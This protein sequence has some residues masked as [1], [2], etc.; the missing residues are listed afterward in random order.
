MCSQVIDELEQY[1]AEANKSFSALFYYG[2]EL[3]QKVYFPAPSYGV[4][5]NTTLTV[6]YFT[7]FGLNLKI[8]MLYNFY[9]R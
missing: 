2:E 6:K 7:E 4:D 3:Y 8:Y 1:D 5:A 9:V